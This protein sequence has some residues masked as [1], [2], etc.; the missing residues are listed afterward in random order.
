MMRRTI[1]AA[2]AVALLVGGCSSRPREF[3]ATLPSAPV[4]RAEFDTVYNKCRT[5]VAQG[6]RSNFGA[7]L[8]SGGLGAAAGVGVT[9]AALSGGSSASSMA[10]AAGA[11]S[12]AIV[13]IP[14]FGLAAAWGVA[15]VSKNRKEHE[16]K[17]A[18]GLCL[19][20]HDYAVN[21]WNVAKGRLAPTA[22]SVSVDPSRKILPITAEAKPQAGAAEETCAAYGERLAPFNPGT[23]RQLQANCEK[24]RK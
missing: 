14:V 3:V 19:S 6:R 12:V 16:V 11:G 13:T 10:V 21:G 9:A 18:M 4:D 24:K 15:K 22:A 7:R 1:F 20:E 8:A 2:A 5:M 17:Q 23:A